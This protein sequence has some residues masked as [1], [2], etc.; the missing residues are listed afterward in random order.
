MNINLGSTPIILR[1]LALAFA[2]SLIGL[3][4]MGLFA[5]SPLVKGWLFVFIMGYGFFGS[6]VAGVMLIAAKR[7]E[8][9]AVAES[10]IAQQTQGTY[11]NPVPQVPVESQPVE[12]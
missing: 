12:E 9:R 4:I 10:I 2:V 3:T 6:I 5:D 8:G 1:G 7:I 11:W